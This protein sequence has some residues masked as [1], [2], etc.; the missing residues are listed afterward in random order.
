MLRAVLA[1][2]LVA[3]LAGAAWHRRDTLARAWAAVGVGAT[4]GGEGAPASVRKCQDGERV[5]YT[6]GACP[7]GTREQGL[8]RGTLSVLPAAPV[9][10]TAASGAAGLPNVRTLLVDPRDGEW[11]QRRID[12][13][14]K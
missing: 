7:P 6:D 8:Q 2:L 14:T 11:K 12:E 1:L 10:A 5:V 3:A 9:A 13:A 4:G